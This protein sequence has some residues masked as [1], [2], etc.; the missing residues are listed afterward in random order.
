VLRLLFC[1]RR[2]PDLSREE[3]SAYWRDVHGPLVVERA[4]SLGFGAYVQ[5]HT[6]DV[7]GLHRYFQ[8]RNDGSPEPYDGLVEIWIDSLDSLRTDEPAK[9][10]AAELLADERNFIDL[11]QSPMWI[12]DEHVFIGAKA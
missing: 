10:A 11:S 7:P 8:Q 12:A 9:K 6:C 3:F 2:R 1:L 5:Y 4:E